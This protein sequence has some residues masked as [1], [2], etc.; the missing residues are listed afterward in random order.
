MST[1]PEIAVD[2]NADVGESFGAFTVGD[3]KA[4]MESVTSVNVAAGFH[5]GDPRTIDRVIRLAA[6]RNIGVGVHP[7]F[8][9][10]VGFGRRDMSLTSDEIRTDVLYQIGAVYGL[11]RAHGVKLQHV[12]PHGQLMNMAVTNRAMA[13]A[14]AG[15]VRAFDPNL[16]LVSYGGELTRAAEAAGIPVAHEVYADR[17]YTAQGTLVSRKLPGAVI[18][19]QGR[20]GERAVRMVRERTVVTITGETLSVRADTICVHADTPGAAEIARSLRRSL[21]AANVT[22]LPLTAV[23]NG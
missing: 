19:D 14:V 13:D 22:V 8:P 15:A 6:D 9:D 4:V 18:Q 20:I 12:K 10:L 7:G 1:M 5:G 16:I 17:E 21:E 23:L 2:L 11:A 3:D